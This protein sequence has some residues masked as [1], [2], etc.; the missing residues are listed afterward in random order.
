MMPV[1][2]WIVLLTRELDDVDDVEVG[3]RYLS[4]TIHG[5][6]VPRQ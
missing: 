5:F 1:E 6:I 3:T 2:W 4:D